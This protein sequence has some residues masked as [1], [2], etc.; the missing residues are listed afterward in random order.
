MLSAA[1]RPNPV[2]RGRPL[3]RPLGHLGL[4][5]ALVAQLVVVLDFSIV[6]VALPSLGRELGASAGDVQWVATAYA[7][8]FGGFLILGGRASDLFGRR[9]L[10]MLGLVVFACASAAGGLSANLTVLAAA[11]AVQ[12]AAAALI[13]P[14]ALSIL[15]TSFP[16]GRER[17]RVLG[18]YGTM[19]SVGFVVGLV[20]GGILVDTVGW[21][22]VFFVNVPLCILLVVV[23]R[24]LPPDV[25]PSGP[26]RLDVVGGLLVTAG[27][28]AL[29]LAPTFGANDGW[30][31]VELLGCLLVAA[32]FLVAYVDH[33]RRTPDPLMPMSIFRRRTLVAG[34]VLAGLLGVWTAGE[35]LVLS[36][37]CQ[38]VLGYSPLLSG[39]IALPQGIGGMLRGIA[40]PRLIDRI[41][42]RRFLVA[43]CAA[44]AVSFFF[45][46]RFPVTTRYPVLGL[47][48]LGVGFSSTS[49]VYA[50][51]IAGSAGVPN[52]DQGLAG[53]II[54]ATRQ[55]GAAVGVALLFSLVA[56]GATPA[57][58]AASYRTALGAATALAV[59]AALVSLAVHDREPAPVPTG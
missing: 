49:V 11:R 10:L 57:R 15:T 52:G 38:Q 8:T 21:R 33:E 58:L 30:T 47:V 44:T 39:L 14:A 7:L 18:Y 37:Y 3:G 29:V 16:E 51:T 17:N 2:E 41:G 35:V 48:L 26:R 42:I 13:A 1:V 54:N 20:A 55:L 25:V 6:N 24:S 53:A 4:I 12:G 43:A 45:L 50:A 28:G 36:L 5:V 46:F 31:S 22:G 19:A 59:V 27:V 9:R 23:G 32:A 40:G 34:D 56:P